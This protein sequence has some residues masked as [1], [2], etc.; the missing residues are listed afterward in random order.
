MRGHLGA[1]GFLDELRQRQRLQCVDAVAEHLQGLGVDERG[2]M[3]GVAHPDPFV[4]GLDDAPIAFFTV[5]QLVRHA[6][7][8]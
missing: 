1:A 3:V 6:L 2:A 5:A 8:Q 7:G 4:R